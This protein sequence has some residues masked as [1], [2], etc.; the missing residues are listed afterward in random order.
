MELSNNIIDDKFEYI[1]F[2]TNQECDNFIIY[3]KNQNI[4][5]IRFCCD[6]KGCSFQNINYDSLKK[7]KAK[8][9]SVY[10][11]FKTIGTCNICFEDNKELFKFCKTCIEPICKECVKQI[12]NCP[13][14]RNKFYTFAHLKR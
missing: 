10:F 9:L 14:C 6:G 12:S 11:E 4:N 8:F 1:H 5:Y 7:L 2:D 3:A 13:F